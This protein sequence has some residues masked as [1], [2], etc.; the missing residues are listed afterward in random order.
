MSH[1]FIRFILSFVL[2]LVLTP[3]TL[4][5]QYD[6]L[7]RGARLLDGTGNPWYYADVAV[8]EDRIV[9]V[10]RLEGATARSVLDATGLYLA[11]G[12]IDVHTHAANGLTTAEL[13]SAHPLLAQGPGSDVHSRS[14]VLAS[15]WHSSS[16][17]IPY[18]DRCWGW[19]IALRPPTNCNA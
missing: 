17:T 19:R 12:F 3:T 10:G 6:I 2:V 15:M 14:M 11:P 18:G 16:P 9:A 1:R 5:A 4:H 7:V 13:S 8:T